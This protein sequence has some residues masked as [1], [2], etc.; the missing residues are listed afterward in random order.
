LESYESV[1]GTR[2]RLRVVRHPVPSR[3]I[4][5]RRTFFYDAGIKACVRVREVVSRSNT[6]RG[7]SFVRRAAVLRISG[8]RCRLAHIE[9]LTRWVA[10]DRYHL[11]TLSH[12]AT[13]NFLSPAMH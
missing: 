6:W 3:S 11:R 5:S 9:L 7:R 1:K 8:R 4:E 12:Q 10:H 13:L 2:L